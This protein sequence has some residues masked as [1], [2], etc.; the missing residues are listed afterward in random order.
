MR[1]VMASPQPPHRRWCSRSRLASSL[2]LSP[3]QARRWERTGIAV[4]AMLLTGALALGAIGC[5]TDWD[6]QLADRAFD[7][8]A[9][10]FPLRHAW[11]TEVFNHVIL[12]RFF[13]ALAVAVVMAVLWDLRSPRA[14]SWLRRFQLRV[15]ALSAVLVPTAIGLLK[16]LSDSHCPWDLERYG[17]TAPYVRLFE[18]WPVGVQAGHCMPAGHASSALWLMSLAVLAL[19]WRPMRAAGLLAATLMLGIGV[20]W[21]QQLRGAHFLTHTLWSAWIALLLVLLVTV[22]LD[23]FPVRQL[24]AR[25]D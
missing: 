15:I 22:C 11:V 21:L 3:A 2:A 9:R 4:V 17:G 1:A 12:K 13:I 19:P 24:A 8:Q 5:W 6:L 14:W 10:V 18:L 7:R 25:G 16:Q 20:G 23:R